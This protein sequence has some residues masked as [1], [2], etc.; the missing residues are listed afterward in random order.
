MYNMYATRAKKLVEMCLSSS[1]SSVM[2]P[3]WETTK[4][5]S[6]EDRDTAIKG[7]L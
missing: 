5:T 7:K 2:L 6:F 3:K 4:G 1:A